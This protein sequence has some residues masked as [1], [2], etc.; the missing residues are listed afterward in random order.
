M[1]SEIREGGAN[2]GRNSRDI[3]MHSR[4]FE[5]R[6]RERDRILVRYSGW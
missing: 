1:R 6:R 4:R 5:N 2:E 3:F